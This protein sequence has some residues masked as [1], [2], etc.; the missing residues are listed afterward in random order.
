M[1]LSD[2]IKQKLDYYIALQY[3]YRN[4]CKY[5]ISNKN[6]IN[7]LMHRIR[8]QKTLACLHN[9]I[10]NVRVAWL[11]VKKMFIPVEFLCI[12]KFVYIISCPHLMDFFFK[13]W[14]MKNVKRINNM[15]MIRIIFVCYSTILIFSTK[16]CLYFLI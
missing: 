10:K 3:W 1:M 12:Q 7:I 5:K 11:G 9:Y 2:I 13:Q 15:Y 8:S 16:C 6:D 4:L 14:R